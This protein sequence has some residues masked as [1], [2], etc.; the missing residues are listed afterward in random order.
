MFAVA[1]SELTELSLE[2]ENKL[3]KEFANEN[4]I[5]TVCLNFQNEW[6]SFLSFSNLGG[7]V[8][9]K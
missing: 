1:T 2:E 8:I 7:G 3:A 4:N 6:N 5:E 9:I